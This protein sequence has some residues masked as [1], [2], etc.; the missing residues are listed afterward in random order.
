MTFFSCKMQYVGDLILLVTHKS[1]NTLFS[2]SCQQQPCSTSGVNAIEK[3]RVSSAKQL[4]EDTT[5]LTGPQRVPWKKQEDSF[6]FALKKQIILSAVCFK[7]SRD[8]FRV[9]QLKK[10]FTSLLLNVNEWIFYKYFLYHL[11]MY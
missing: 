9:C 8:N 11:L 4:T 10:T 5:R 3:Q 1:T 7:T 2:I 6:A